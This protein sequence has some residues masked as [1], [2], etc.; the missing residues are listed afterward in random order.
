M[1]R[2]GHDIKGLPV[3]AGKSQHMVFVCSFYLQRNIF[4]MAKQLGHLLPK[5]KKRMHQPKFNSGMD[6]VL[7]RVVLPCRLPVVGRLQPFLATNLSFF[8]IDRPAVIGINQAQ[9]PAFAALVNI[10]RAGAGKL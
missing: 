3:P 6:G 5:P 10:G 7:S 2:Y 9:V 4:A 8:V 1:Q